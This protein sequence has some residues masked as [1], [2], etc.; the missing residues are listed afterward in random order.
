MQGLD[1]GRVIAR[2]GLLELLELTR[3]QEWQVAALTDI[4]N[5]DNQ[6][7]GGAVAVPPG[8]EV[9]F[10]YME[11]YMWVATSDVAVQLNPQGREAFRRGGCI[12]KSKSG[13]MIG[14][15]LD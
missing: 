14:I 3:R 2:D 10:V 9:V 6:A 8:N 4:H 11:E 13:I 1:W 15:I 5:A 12:V 7:M